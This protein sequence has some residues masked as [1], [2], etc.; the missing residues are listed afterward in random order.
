MTLSFKDFSLLLEGREVIGLSRE[1]AAGEILTIMGASGSG[2]SSFLAAI[3]GHLPPAFS[4]D[5]EILRDGVPILKQPAH[6]RQIGAVFQD[7]L[8]F[9]HLSVG[10]NLA[11][12]LAPGGDRRR[13]VA[14][15]LEQIGLDGFA[16][17]DPSSLSGGQ[18]ARVALMRALLAQPRA[19]LLDEPFSKL[20]QELRG[21]MRDLTFEQIRSRAIP[22]ILVT[23]DL[24]DARAAGGDVIYI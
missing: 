5:G 19:L 18:A 10:A 11:F 9:P 22:A 13:K 20:D 1:V 15:G 24:E 6:H 7:A 4:T 14:R 2:K 12:G 17:R 21:R 23:H 3:S 8:L 16:A